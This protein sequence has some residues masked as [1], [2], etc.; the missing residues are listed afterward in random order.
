M[1]GIWLFICIRAIIS[2]F[3][4][5]YNKFNGIAKLAIEGLFLFLLIFENRSRYLFLY[6]PVLLTAIESDE[7]IRHAF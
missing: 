3:P 1:Q 7:R 6:L 2:C 4:Q 5:K